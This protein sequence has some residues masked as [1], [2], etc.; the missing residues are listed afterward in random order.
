MSELHPAVD[1][2]QLEATLEAELGVGIA[3]LEVLAEGLNFVLG[4]STTD[5]ERYVLRRRNELSEANY[6]GG[7]EDEYGLLQG[8]QG[9][10]VPAPEPVAFFE[11]DSLVGG[12]C[13]LMS[14][15][16]G[17]PVTTELP[18]DHRDPGS[19]ARLGEL[20]VDTLAGVHSLDADAFE[21]GCERVSPRQHVERTID[22]LDEVTAVTGRDLPRLYSVGDWLRENAPSASRT[23][24][25][26]GDFR[27][28]NFLFTW[29]GDPEV[30]TVLDWETA[31]L[32]DP[33]LDLGYLLL[34][35][36]DDG[37]PTPDVAALEDEYPGHDAID[38]L[39]DSAREGMSPFTARPGSPTRRDLV[40]RY[41]ATTGWEFENERFYRAEA[42]FD[43]AV[44]WE[45]I[46]R[47]RV[48]AGEDSEWEPYVE[49]VA[50][51]AENVVE[52]DLEL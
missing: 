30:T 47:N 42:A 38:D 52:G 32:S 1:A 12:E 18:A 31:M 13:F 44:V 37:D 24:L 19:R 16:E 14:Y 35:W 22:R 36:R 25:V 9:S 50:M 34:R 17:E 26:H 51:V 40:D 43:L 23:S 4:V 27:P 10:P 2:S 5:G 11:D 8:L 46:H 20:L 6:I 48:E 39:R 45:D 41:E 21:G 28:G 7:I 49:Y 29:D 15:H 33:L 3:D